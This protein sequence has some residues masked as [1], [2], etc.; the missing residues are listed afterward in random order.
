[1]TR[2][3]VLA[4]GRGYRL[5]ALLDAVFFH[6]IPDFELVAVISPEENAYALTRAQTAGIPGY[7][8]DPDLFPSTSSY[9]KA[10][11]NKL[12]DMDIDLVILADYSLPLGEVGK[13]YKNR[14]I[15]VAPSL[16]PAFENFSG[17]MYQV[18]HDRGIKV[19]GATAYFAAEDGSIGPIILQKTVPL[20]P[21]MDPDAIR[22]RIL[23]DAEWV[24][25][26]EA[27]KLF[28]GNKLECNGNYVRIAGQ[29]K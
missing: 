28:C 14:I 21:E 5:Q 1:M 12:K 7:V 23:E 3:A 22:T 10:I 4:E 19:A 16:I 29:D 9:C 11:S 18:L 25:L 13:R 27:V 8:V 2:G 6:E 26:P 15:G 24:L 17:N 20:D